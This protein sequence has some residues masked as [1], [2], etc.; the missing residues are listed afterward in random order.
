MYPHASRIQTFLCARE[1]D[2]FC[3]ALD[4]ALSHSLLL[5]PPVNLDFIPQPPSTA[6]LHQCAQ[7]R[8]Y[9]SE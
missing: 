4:P 1:P 3:F 8:G 6:S 2:P 5:F 7:V 9:V